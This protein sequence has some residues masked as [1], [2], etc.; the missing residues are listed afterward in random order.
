MQHQVHD[1]S[2]SRKQVKVP[3]SYKTPGLKR[4]IWYCQQLGLHCRFIICEWQAHLDKYLRKLLSPQ[5]E[6]VARV[7]GRRK[8]LESTEGG[9]CSSTQREEAEGGSSQTMMSEHL[10]KYS[11]FECRESFTARECLM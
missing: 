10:G 1:V 3:G 6:E 8:L 11:E 9:S 5:K 7:H 4:K 2:N